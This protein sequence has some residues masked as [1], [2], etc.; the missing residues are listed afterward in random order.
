MH[1]CRSIFLIRSFAVLLGFG[2]CA[3]VAWA[4]PAG[5]SYIVTFRDSTPQA[6]R[7]AAVRAAGARVRF[8]YSI[9]NAAAVT[10]PNANA[11]AALGR[12]PRVL[13]ITRDLPVRAIVNA[14]K[15]GG[16]GGGPNGGGG[17][18]G[19]SSQIIPDGVD[20]L[21][22]RPSRSDGSGVIDGSDVGILI[23]DTGLDWNHAD[24][25]I[26]TTF[27]DAFEG[28]CQ[29]GNGHGTHVAGTA[30]AKDNKIDVIGVAPGA[31][32]YCGKALDDSG[33]GHDSTVIAVLEFALAHHDE[34]Q[35]VNLSLGRKKS[36]AAEYQ[37]LLDALKNLYDVEI[38][39]VTSAG[40]DPY[41]EV[42]DMLPSGSP[43]VIAVASTTAKDGN[44][45]CRRL[46]SPILKDTAS[47][48]TTDGVYTEGFGGVTIS[49]P[50]E[51][52]EDVNRGCF[53]KSNGIL[54]LAVGGGT[55]DKIQ[56]S[57][58]SG[59]SMASPHVAGVAALYL[60]SLT[61][62]PPTTGLN[63]VDLFRMSLWRNADRYPD[64]A[65]LDSPSSAYD[66]DGERE[67]IAQVP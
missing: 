47:Y 12:N 19:G 38:I 5:D 34:I 36:T 52:S 18:G 30:A 7:A 20:R 57:P 42:S 56:G 44:N 23:G 41:A 60:D 40:N 25:N 65:P 66:Y 48:F 1:I 37:P 8:N 2:V 4:Q 62:A 21:G 26:A 49:A 11:L 63:I 27:F 43:H 35:V 33:S 17:G 51:T 55:T 39:V 3:A 16:N 13:R 61:S 67:G 28:S 14:N 54:S 6:D 24:L 10:V 22:T 50:G 29:D 64:Q 31:T 45:R 15:R 58:A 32:L 53:I 46:S 9:I 59:T